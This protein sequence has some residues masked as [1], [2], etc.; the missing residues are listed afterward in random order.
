[1]FAGNISYVSKLL[2]IHLIMKMRV[3]DWLV[4]EVLDQVEVVEKGLE[5]ESLKVIAKV[6]HD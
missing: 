2:A 4:K 6:W 3:I 5:V 1:M